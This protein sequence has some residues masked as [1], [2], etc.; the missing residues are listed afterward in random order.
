M[1]ISSHLAEHS[2]IQINAKKFST[3]ITETVVDRLRN[4]S[5]ECLGKVGL[6]KP[7]HIVAPLTVEP[8]KPRLCINLMYL[9]NWIKDISF[10]LD[11]LKNVPRAVREN[12]YFTSIDDKSGFDNVMLSEDSR[13]LVG[14][15]WGGFYFIFKTLPFG[16]KLSSYIYHTLNL[17]ATSYI[18]RKFLIPVHLYIDDRLV[19][20][21]RKPGL[22]AGVSSALL[23]NYI[24]CEVITRLGYCINLDKTV[25]IPSQSVVFLGFVVD[26][27]ARCFRIT[28]SKKQKFINLRED[29]L[30]K[31][32]ITVLDLQKIVGRCISFML[33]V[34][35][36]KLYTREMNNAISLGIRNQTSIPMTK[37]LKDE[38]NNWR[39]LDSWTGKLEWKK[40][41]HLVV[42]IYTDA[43]MFKWG[44]YFKINDT[45]HK[46][47]DSWAH[48]MLSLPIM[49]LE[50]KALLYVLR[51]IREDI[52]GSRVDANVDNQALIGAWNNEGSKSMMLNSTLKEIFQL[53]LDLDVML[54]LHFVPSK[55]NL[56]DEP[57]RKLS[58]S[59]AKLNS[60]IW[61]TIQEYF[62][63]N[64]GHTIDLMALDS[65]SMNDRNGRI[66][67][68][69]TPT[70]SPLSSGVN[71]F[72]QAVD[73]SENC[74]VFPPFALLLPVLSFIRE[75]MLN[76]TVIL[77]ADGVI[78]TWVP[79]FY[80]LI[81]D[82]FI[83][84]NKGQKGVLKYPTKKGYDPDGIGL[85]GNL[86]AVRI[87]SK[88]SLCF[89]YGK[90]LFLNE[91]LIS[92][93]FHLL[94]I[95][96]SMIRFLQWRKDF[97]NPM[98]NV[99]SQGGALV[100]E[101]TPQIERLT[102]MH[103]PRLLFIH[104]GV[105]NVSKSFLFESEFSQLLITTQQLEHLAHILQCTRTSDRH[106]S[107]VLSSII[108][109]KDEAINARSAI[110]NEK[111]ESLCK[112]N[113]WMFM[114][115]SNINCRHL[116]DCSI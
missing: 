10:S 83:V 7:P 77:R 76:C 63:D 101:I 89:N 97:K 20:E 59:D 49:V 38:L 5:I 73:K 100:S 111:I 21:V 45:E 37:D 39:F 86:W 112:R 94:C 14:F 84:G 87:S 19:E 106:V 116:R 47:G 60:D 85:S 57:S 71:L 18:R 33:A 46:V 90:L 27:V 6:A 34:P 67:K 81:H 44:G 95:G 40:E 72:A 26:S 50:A 16:F 41:R 3:F 35:A 68:H 79:T 61:S 104:V 15:Q 43:S 2:I 22:K 107:I 29:C 80:E 42:N 13:G 30:R 93:K 102:R 24:V 66:L 69:F 75:N 28:E 113:C 55:L 64:T 74:Y 65:N 109:C 115:N 103:P 8:T 51:S 54:N 52:K 82:A 105:N 62:G 88:Q 48:E 110:I 114:D 96:D 58:K 23:A 12:A 53:T 92:T 98:V 31:S 25:F 56:A 1:M 70:V 99:F 9:N 108:R 17:Q 36:A 91:P 11:T 4:G 78:A 32:A